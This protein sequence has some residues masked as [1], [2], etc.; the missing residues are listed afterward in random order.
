[1]AGNRLQA[2]SGRAPG[3]NVGV[4]PCYRPF[5]TAVREAAE[6]LVSAPDAGRRVADRRRG[7]SRAGRRVARRQRPNCLTEGAQSPKIGGL[8][9]TGKVGLQISQIPPERLTRTEA[10][11]PPTVPRR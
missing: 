3:A 1:P 8:D 11:D 5:H 10:P 7:G 9:R 4:R 2:S 6:D